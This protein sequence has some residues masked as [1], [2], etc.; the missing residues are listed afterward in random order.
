ME[1]IERIQAELLNTTTRTVD[2]DFCSAQSGDYIVQS[3]RRLMSEYQIVINLRQ[4]TADFYVAFRSFVGATKTPLELPSFL[5]TDEMLSRFSIVRL[6]NKRYD[7]SR[8]FPQYINSEFVNRTFDHASP[9][10]NSSNNYNL[11][12]S[13][14]IC[15]RLIDRTEYKNASQQ[16]A[17]NAALSMEEGNTALICMPTGSGKSMITQ[18]LAYQTSIGLTVVIVPTVSLAIDQALEATAT[19][20]GNTDNEIFCYYGNLDAT[21]LMNSLRTHKARL[22]FISPEALQLNPQLKNEMLTLSKIGYIRN[23]VIDEAHMV[24]EWGSSFRLDYQT[25]ESFRNQMLHNNKSIRTYL[26]SATYDRREID[27]LK[28]LF[29]ENKS[30]LEIRCDMLRKEPL[31]TCIKASNVIEKEKYALKLIDLL[32]RPMIIYVRSPEDADDIS[33]QLSNHGYANVKTFTGDTGKKERDE[34]INDWKMNN[35]ST[36]IATSAFGIGVNKSDVRTILHLHAPENPNFYYQEVG[37]GGR[38]GYPSLGVMC[39]YPTIDLKEAHGFSSRVLSEDKLITRWFSMLSNSKRFGQGNDEYIVIDTSVLPEYSL[40]GSEVSGNQKHIFWNVYVLMLLRRYELIEIT[41]IKLKNKD[42]F[43]E[44][45]NVYLVYLRVNDKKLLVKS[46]EAELM[47]KELRR[48]ESD[49]YEKNYSIV[50]RAINH[51]DSECW[52]EMFYEVFDQVDMYCPGCDI[53]N[54]SSGT[55]NKK[56]FPLR[57]KVA[58]L[59]PPYD[60]RLDGF[61]G[62]SREAF[63]IVT[64]SIYDLLKQLVMNGITGIIVCGTEESFKTWVENIQEDIQLSSFHFAFLNVREFK[65]LYEHGD[66]FYLCGNYVIVYGDIVNENKVALEISKGLISRGVDYKAIHV[67]NADFSLGVPERHISECIEGPHYDDN[68]IKGVIDNV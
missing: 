65:D 67:A 68:N 6:A 45:K 52:S 27:V 46:N 49:Y 59:R 24:V 3:A 11:Y 35:S 4:P 33:K 36:L 51:S 42:K 25:L 1:L 18:S 61:I 26:L 32:P 50:E 41:D 29:A 30:W 21:R 48:L 37:R 2:C 43:D 13:P 55:Y 62:E 44:Y 23:L 57:K 39:I 9:V 14:Y 38:D 40:K 34:I 8:N 19:V 10:N 7:I 66:W 22:L 12:S 28:T 64:K 58:Q 5:A 53:H 31:F 63:I 15:Q 47:L 20:R 16:L 56:E 54:K 17:I 60:H